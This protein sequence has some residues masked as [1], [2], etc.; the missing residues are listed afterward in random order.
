MLSKNVLFILSIVSD[1]SINPY[2]IHRLINIK[3]E[4]FRSAI[5]VQ[6]VYS[7]IKALLK[8]ELVTREVVS[9]DTVPAKTMYSI[10]LKGMG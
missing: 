3:R 8:K 9:N 7:V 4:N 5:P 2:S 1:G 6:T 10:T